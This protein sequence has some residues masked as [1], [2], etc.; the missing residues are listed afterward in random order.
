MGFQKTINLDPAIGMPGAEVNPGQ[1]VYTAFNFV[2]DGTVRAGTFAFAKTLDSNGD[3]ITKM[4]QASATSD[5]G[6]KVL[7]F[8]E[9]NLIG[10]LISP[11]VEASDVYSAGLGL[12]IAIRGQFYAIA[13]GAAQAGQSVLCDPAT[14]NVTYGA[15]GAAN[16]TGWVVKFPRGVSEVAEGDLVIYENFGVSVAAA[17]VV[18]SAD[19]TVG[20]ARVGTSKVAA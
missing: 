16:D 4:N 3:P 13:S 20:K 2:S 18:S 12:P 10:N 8:V 19:E 7:G 17:S 9:R 15:A 14:G 1:A 11:L 6:A 5:S